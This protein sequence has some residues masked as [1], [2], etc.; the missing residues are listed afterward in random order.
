MGSH[1]GQ[2]VVSCLL[3]R[4]AKNVRACFN[5]IQLTELEKGKNK[6]SDAFLTK[7]ETAHLR[8]TQTAINCLNSTES[9]Q[10]LDLLYHYWGPCWCSAREIAPP[11]GPPAQCNWPAIQPGAGPSETGSSLSPSSDWTAALHTNKSQTFVRPSIIAAPTVR[12]CE[13]KYSCL[14]LDLR[15]L[16]THLPKYLK[17]AV[18][19]GS[20]R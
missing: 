19:G 13:E 8:G 2:I 10:R 3:M 4:K 17:A 20:S 11:V 1:L 16:S 15:W 7:D 12:S 9:T 5:V 6:T 18:A 14:S